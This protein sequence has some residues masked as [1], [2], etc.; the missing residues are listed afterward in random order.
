MKRLLSLL[1]VLATVA[2]MLG[3]SGCYTQIAVR[4]EYPRYDEYDS[5]DYSET[6]VDDSGTV[7]T[8]NYYYDSNP[9]SS[10]YFDFYYPT[11]SG[12][13]WSMHYDPWYDWYRPAY[14]GY[15]NNYWDPFYYGPSWYWHR[16]YHY[17]PYHSMAYWGY[18]GSSCCSQWNSDGSCLTE[19][20]N[21]G[22]H[23]WCQPELRYPHPK[24]CHAKW[25]HTN[26]DY[27]H[28]FCNDPN[29]KRRHKH[30]QR[31]L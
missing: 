19:R 10:A 17:H 22:A 5:P 28:T 13:F 15:Y 8:D 12:S 18:L 2:I 21:P 11:R 7:V 24:R 14:Y 25:R 29:A 1:P 30:T 20:W 3:T 4:D 27:L 6:Y 31:G 9:R 16:P 23:K 26:R